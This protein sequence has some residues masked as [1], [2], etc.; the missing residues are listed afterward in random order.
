VGNSGI[1]LGSGCGPKIDTRD[2]I[3]FLNNAPTLA[4]VKR[5]AAGRVV[6]AKRQWWRAV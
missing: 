2:F 4:P 5:Y 3:I 1:V 6:R